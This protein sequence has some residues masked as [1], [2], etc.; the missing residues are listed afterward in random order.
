MSVRFVH[1]Y[2]PRIIDAHG[3]DCA[4]V[5]L[6]NEAPGPDE[7]DGGIPLFG[8]QGANVF[9]ALRRAGVGW[10]A[11]HERFVWPRTPRASAVRLAKK[12]AFLSSRAKYITCTNSYPQWPKLGPEGRGFAPP[13]A[14]D[15]KSIENLTRIQTE[16]LPSHRVVLICGASAYLACYGEPLMKPQAREGTELDEAELACI[17]QR[18]LASFQAGWYLGHTRRWSTQQAAIRRAL[19]RVSVQA[20]WTSIA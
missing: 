1:S 20:G 9:H 12:T 16:I 3:D 18:L 15:V 7:A 5:M 10:A 14:V 2:D 6:M 11:A 8:Q 13:D 4:S 19:E 17:N